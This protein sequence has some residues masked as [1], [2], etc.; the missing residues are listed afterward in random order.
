MKLKLTEVVFVVLL[1]GLG[2]IFIIRRRKKRRW[3][4][5]N[6]MEDSKTG[7]NDDHKE[8]GPTFGYRDTILGIPKH[9]R[10][11][12]KGVSVKSEKILEKSGDKDLEAGPTLIHEPTELPTESPASDMST[13]PRVITE[14]QDDFSPE[15]DSTASGGQPPQIGTASPMIKVEEWLPEVPTKA[16]LRIVP[17]TNH[18]PRKFE[19]MT[20]TL[21]EIREHLTHSSLEVA[22]VRPSRAHSKRWSATTHSS[23]YTASSRASTVAYVSPLQPP[24]MPRNMYARNS[25]A[26]SPNLK[27][28]SVARMDDIGKRV[29][30]VKE[31]EIF[32]RPDSGQAPP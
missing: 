7:G 2:A 4:A 8:A 24:P 28:E 12:S 16:A 13:F 17:V 26:G 15:N 31:G 30:I 11:I 23:T 21:A 18:Y 5:Q 29:S 25:W 10:K 9:E 20:P 6:K 19:G 14:A 1:A 32:G 27:H 3:L 22:G